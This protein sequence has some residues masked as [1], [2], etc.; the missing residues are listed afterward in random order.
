[1]RDPAATL[2]DRL[3]EAFAGNAFPMLANLLQRD[4]I[5]DLIGPMPAPLIA[6]LQGTVDFAI[7]PQVDHA[8]AILK[9]PEANDARV[10]VGRILSVAPHRCSELFARHG[11]SAPDIVDSIC[12]GSKRPGPPE[13]A[14]PE[15]EVLIECLND[16]FTPMD[17]VVELFQ[18][19]F[20]LHPK[21]AVAAMLRVH[22]EQSTP[23]IRLPGREAL[24]TLEAA[25]RWCRARSVGLRL[26]IDDDP[27]RVAQFVPLK[28][29]DE[30][31]TGK[32][33]HRTSP[34]IW[35][36]LLL[37]LVWVISSLIATDRPEVG[38][39]GVIAEIPEQPVATPE[40][41]RRIEAA[42]APFLPA[43]Q[44]TTREYA[45]IELTPTSDD[46]PWSS[47]VGG[48]PYLPAGASLPADPDSPGRPMAL[49]AQID[50]AELPEMAGYPRKG[51]LQFFV[52][53]DADLRHFGDFRGDRVRQQ[54][55]Q[56]YFR[57]IYWADRSAELGAHA[58][59][60]PT[61]SPLMQDSVLR[62]SFTRA[63]EVITPADSSFQR[64]VGVDPFKLAENLAKE[65]SM[66]I[67]A[68]ADALP[69]A[70]GRG[71]KVG[72]WPDFAQD[73]P[74]AADSTLQLLLQLDSD[75]Y[76]MWGD[77]GVGNFF[78]PAED[79]ARLDFS[80]VMFNW[81]SH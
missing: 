37:G 25:E 57:V 31:V 68:V 51:L 41:R 75:K 33:G 23:I 49:L 43:L 30:A 40:Q 58:G 78:I 80:R 50:F 79:L 53:E 44:A 5:V 67:M 46:E 69:L 11:V 56:T 3:R 20:G 36:L 27:E 12:R 47:K 52:A 13:L 10:L 55:R 35:A 65:L 18:S 29:F 81:D 1:M 74:R 16:D 70:S 62:M 60:L 17:V 48:I 15:A 21:A 7:N 71:H 61:A 4:E 6:E 76:L 24:L 42:F 34:V 19:C 72:G 28:G 66:P 63:Q 26:R 73:D 45:R 77:A 59:S 32:S 2:S 39:L 14:S 8:L 54:S 64:R 9:H 38:T 22:N